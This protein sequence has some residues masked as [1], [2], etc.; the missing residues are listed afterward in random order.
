MD[1]IVG[2]PPFGP[3]A[4]NKWPCYHV[5]EPRIRAR[6][7]ADTH[8]RFLSFLSP[9]LL[10]LLLSPMFATIESTRDFLRATLRPDKMEPID[11]IFDLG[12]RERRLP[13]RARPKTA[14]LNAP[15][16]GLPFD[17]ADIT[18]LRLLRGHSIERRV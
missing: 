15:F 14:L 2:A 16:I 9:P 10:T 5:P 17:R 11:A 13:G 18:S 8:P 7:L 12:E 4:N 3:E 1:G 6:I